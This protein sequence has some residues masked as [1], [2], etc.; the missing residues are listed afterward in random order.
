MDEW[1]LL[2]KLKTEKQTFFIS[3]KISI[4]K[5]TN[6]GFSSIINHSFSDLKLMSLTSFYSRKYK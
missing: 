6:Q 2:S 1:A 5:W 3:G 4:T